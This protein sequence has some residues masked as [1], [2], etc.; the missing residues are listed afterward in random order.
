MIIAEI[1]LNHNGSFEIAKQYVSDLCETKIDGI[2]FQVR[3]PA[4]YQNEYSKYSLQQTE[5]KEL[6]R[7][8]KKTQKKVGIAIAD[9]YKIDFFDSLQVDLYKVIR[10]DLLDDSMM[11]KL[12]STGKEIIVSTGLCSDEEI[13]KFIIKHGSYD[14]LVLNHT[15]LS[16]NVED[17]NLLAIDK[18]KEKY[19]LPV[20]FGS[21]CLDNKVIYLSLCYNPHHILF[22]VKNNSKDHF[23]DSKHAILLSEVEQTIDNIKTLSTSIGSG[24]KKAFHNKMENE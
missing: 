9:A 22:Y 3:E 15:Q 10:K 14:K 7:Q 18:M 11:K 24:H 13:Q 17:C 16:Y 6:I 4:F 1:G 21:H 19:N 5:Y 8:I 20:S 12:K 2:T 23:L